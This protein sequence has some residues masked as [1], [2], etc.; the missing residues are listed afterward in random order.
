MSA[1]R[2]SKG[3]ARHEAAR[4]LRRYVPRHPE[5]TRLEEIL[6]DAEVFLTG[7]KIHTERGLPKTNHFIENNK[8]IGWWWTI[9]K[10]SPRT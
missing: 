5:E 4:I 7:W 8:A 9:Q 2:L 1:S 10:D 3:K 6:S